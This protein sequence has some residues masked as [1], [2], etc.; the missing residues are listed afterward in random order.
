[1][2]TLIATLALVA[3]VATHA[4]AKHAVYPGRNYPCPEYNQAAQSC[5]VHKVQN[6]KANSGRQNGQENIRQ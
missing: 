6:I 4:V 2:K 3:L 1:M 5:G